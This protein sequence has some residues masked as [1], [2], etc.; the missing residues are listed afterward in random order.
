[1]SWKD[2][3]YKPFYITGAQP[4]GVIQTGEQIDFPIDEDFEEP[5]QDWK[6]ENYEWRDE[7]EDEGY[8]EEDPST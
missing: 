7:W 3:E 6:A 5:L 8:E 1:M 2:K 4:K